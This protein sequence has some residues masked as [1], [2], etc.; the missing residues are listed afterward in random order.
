MLEKLSLQINQID[1]WLAANTKNDEISKSRLLNIL[2]DRAKSISHAMINYFDLLKTFHIPRRKPSP[3]LLVVKPEIKDSNIGAIANPQHEE[4]L[5]RKFIDQ[6]KQNDLRLLKS[7]LSALPD[8]ENH[9]R[10]FNNLFNNQI[11]DYRDASDQLV[12]IYLVN[13]L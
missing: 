1:F 7:Y 6:F 9:S 2:R 8:K 13:Y 5:I 3:K 12:S 10:L 11:T 4:S